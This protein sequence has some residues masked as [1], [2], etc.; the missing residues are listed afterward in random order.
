M[1]QPHFNNILMTLS[2]EHYHGVTSENPEQI[3]SL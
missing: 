3:G 1:N 2:E